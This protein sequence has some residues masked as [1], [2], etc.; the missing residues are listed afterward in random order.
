MACV[1][2][3]HAGLNISQA[4][5]E[6]LVECL[7]ALISNASRQIGSLPYLIASCIPAKPVLGF[8]L[9]VVRYIPL[10]VIICWYEQAVELDGCGRR[11]LALSVRIC[12]TNRSSRSSGERTNRPGA[13]WRH[14]ARI[15]SNVRSADAGRSRRLPC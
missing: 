12:A 5:G 13:G 14:M 4:G 1:L 9:F 3:R 2:V 6:T 8:F 11:P 7:L 10:P 15:G